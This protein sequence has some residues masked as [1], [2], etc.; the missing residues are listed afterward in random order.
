M[1]M[2]KNK[3]IQIVTL[4]ACVGAVIITANK[5]RVRARDLVNASKLPDFKWSMDGDGNKLP[6]VIDMTL[7]TVMAAGA[8]AVGVAVYSNMK[9]PESIDYL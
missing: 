8:V 2:N 4:A 9:T 3:M 6:D 5:V 1:D 7:N